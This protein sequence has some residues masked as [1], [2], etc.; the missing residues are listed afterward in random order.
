MTY[1]ST[2]STLTT[3]LLPFVKPKC[4]TSVKNVSSNALGLIKYALG[5]LLYDIKN[6]I[7]KMSDWL[8]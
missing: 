4:I 7:N 1:L 5:V 6:V 2:Y 3:L 8:P